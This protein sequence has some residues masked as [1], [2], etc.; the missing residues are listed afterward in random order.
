MK[1]REF[2]IDLAKALGLILL[3]AF[4]LQ[5]KWYSTLIVI[6]CYFLLA[7]RWQQRKREACIQQQ[8]LEEASLYMEQL[9]Y[10]F[11]QN[12]Q[13]LSSLEDV[14]PLFRQGRMKECIKGAIGRM[15]AEHDATSR[16]A[17]GIIEKEYDCDRIR[18]I[19]TYLLHVEQYGGDFA[20]TID[21]LLTDVH[22]Y[23]ERV[24]IYQEDCKK[25]RRNVWI[26]V[27]LSVLICGITNAL[28]PGDLEVSRLAVCQGAD[29]LMLCLDML[30]C[31]RTLARTS[32][33]WLKTGDL[34][35]Q[36]EWEKHYEE[37]KSNHGL[38]GVIYRKRLRKKLQ[39]AFPHWLMEIA[40]LLQS[41]NV[42]VAMHK[43]RQ[44]APAVL[45]PAIGELVEQLNQNPESIKPYMSFLEDYHIPDVPSA[46]RMLYALSNGGYGDGNQQLAQIMQRN[47]ELLDKAERTQNEDSLAG[48]YALFLAPALTGAGK[49]LVDMTMFLVVFLSQMHM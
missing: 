49:M 40:L 6:L 4:I 32:K 19:H 12:Q 9:L 20:G 47:Q 41:E 22:Q 33:D 23:M 14:Y 16:E 30:L 26:A 18:Q 3:A 48:M 38:A 34:G 28:L 36:K 10:A 25:Y 29:V 13:I 21:Y 45:R 7:F 2:F 17:L 39:I 46:M 44:T 42:Q 8:R 37:C 15:K 11:L 5:M 43:T 24:R 35:D 27:A 31:R 1:H